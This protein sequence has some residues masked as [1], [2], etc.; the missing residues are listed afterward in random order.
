MMGGPG[1]HLLAVGGS[2]MLMADPLFCAYHIRRA[3]RGRRMQA[4]AHCLIALCMWAIVLALAIELTTPI[5]MPFKLEEI[6]SFAIPLVVLGISVY[7][8]RKMW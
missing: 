6:L 4:V 1:V 3:P 2:L 7:V 8:S 5:T